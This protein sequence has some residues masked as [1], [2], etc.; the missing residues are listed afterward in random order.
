MKSI[1]MINQAQYERDYIFT[2]KHRKIKKKR[3]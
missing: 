3:Q 1:S 2:V